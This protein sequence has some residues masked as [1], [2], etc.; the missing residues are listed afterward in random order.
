MTEAPRRG[1][2]AGQ[3]N[4]DATR[5][6]DWSSV[7]DDEMHALGIVARSVGFGETWR[8]VVIIK[9]D[10][11]DDRVAA[12]AHWLLEH[13]RFPLEKEPHHALVCRA[14]TWTEGFS[15]NDDQEALMRIAERR[16]RSAP[17]RP[18]SSE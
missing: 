12:A 16:R 13:R 6:L 5:D 7:D 15:A 1:G 9:R 18:A 2:A 8:P 4:R 17:S 11:A 10:L 14:L 3:P